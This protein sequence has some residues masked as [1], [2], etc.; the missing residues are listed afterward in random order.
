MNVEQPKRPESMHDLIERFM[1]LEG[2]Y[3]MMWAQACEQFAAQLNNMQERI[4]MLEKE[5]SDG[6]V[7]LH[8]G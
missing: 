2:A 4:D 6:K 1:W 5:R 7:P 3:H 8:Q